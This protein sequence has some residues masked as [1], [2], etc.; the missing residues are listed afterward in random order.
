MVFYRKRFSI[1][2]I[3]GDIKSRG[4]NLQKLRVK[5][6]KMISNILIIVCL[7][8]LIVFAIGLNQQQIKISRIIRKDRVDDYSIF[9]IGFR[10][11]NYI[12]ENQIDIFYKLNSIFKPYFCVRF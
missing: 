10:I 12:I 4:F 9:Q 1:E 7:A 8:F 6:P 3:F 2:T 11:A 5:D